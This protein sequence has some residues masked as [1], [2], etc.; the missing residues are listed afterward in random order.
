MSLNKA[1][2]EALEDSLQRIEH[3]MSRVGGGSAA[4]ATLFCKSEDIKLAIAAQKATMEL[5]SFA[6]T[7][8][9]AE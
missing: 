1:I 6:K 8:G 9:V 7:G 5:E 3:K 4:D 2:L